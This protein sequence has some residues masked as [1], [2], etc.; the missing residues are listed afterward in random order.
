MPDEIEDF[1]IGG[2]LSRIRFFIIRLFAGKM[3]VILNA[4][5]SIQKES[6]AISMVTIT[7]MDS[8]MMEHD[9]FQPEVIAGENYIIKI[10]MA[11]HDC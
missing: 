10:E 5:I 7:N 1:E 3:L 4:K 6:S 2:L 9:S 11:R 8:V